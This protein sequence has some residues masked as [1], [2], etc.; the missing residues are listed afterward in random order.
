[1][2]ILQDKKNKSR[3]SWKAS[4]RSVVVETPQRETKGNP[5]VP[6]YIKQSPQIAQGKKKVSLTE[7][8]QKDF[9]QSKSSLLDTR[10]QFNI[11]RQR[12]GIIK[13]L[14]QRNFV[15]EAEKIK[16]CRKE[17][18][19]YS[20]KSCGAVGVF[21]K[22]CNSRICPICSRNMKNRLIAKYEKGFKNLSKFY[23]SRLKLLTLTTRNVQSLDGSVNA[24]S[25]I[26]IAFNKFRRR[27]SL[28]NKIFGGLY[29][30]ETTFDKAK[31]WNLHLH[32]LVSMRYHQVACEG[33][34]KCKDRE[35][36]REFERVHCSV[37]RSKCLRRFWEEASGGSSILDIR[38]VY[39]PR[40]AVV[41][42]VGYLLKAV[43]S[44]TPER[45]ID[46]W[47]ATKRKPCVKSFGCF[48]KLDFEK[49]KLVCPFCGGTKFEIHSEGFY[50]LV[51]MREDRGRSPPGGEEEGFFVDPSY[52]V[53]SEDKQGFSHITVY[54]LDGGYIRGA[55]YR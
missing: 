35:E 31:G 8:N 2:L 47:S 30:I 43:P 41:E 55:I 52:V 38:R 26:R 6:F 11:N 5:A 10:K 46:W 39:N 12:Q 17:R 16:N 42:V 29:A 24:F 28:V 18:N 15:F 51:D 34:K 45:L 21:F 7:E 13:V 37:C 36:E 53:E 19:F 22:S 25:A 54:I 32:C 49:P 4:S 3:D 14:E 20:C 40:K 48:R 27:K 23:R 1:M 33:M 44:G 50:T 9:S